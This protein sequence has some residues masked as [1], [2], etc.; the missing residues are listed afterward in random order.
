MVY[1]EIQWKCFAWFYI[2]DAL[3]PIVAVYEIWIVSQNLAA[4]LHYSIEA[5]EV[6]FSASR[7][8]KSVNDKHVQ[9]RNATFV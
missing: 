1:I 4:K 3:F 2:Y 6:T 8:Y 5:E 9:F 7:M